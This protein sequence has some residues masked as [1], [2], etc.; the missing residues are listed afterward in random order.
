MQIARLIVVAIISFILGA[1]T[2][3]LQR[4]GLQTDL[5]GEEY[6]S[7]SI[8]VSSAPTN[9]LTSKRRALYD[10]TIAMAEQCY[11]NSKDTPDEDTARTCESMML[12]ASYLQ[13]LLED[14]DEKRKLME[15]TNTAFIKYAG[16]QKSRIVEA[17]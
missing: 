11:V 7:L 16:T 17:E 8:E 9:G 12:S 4:P 1:L 6:N 2:I 14:R 10:S 5:T 13:N 3:G 15:L